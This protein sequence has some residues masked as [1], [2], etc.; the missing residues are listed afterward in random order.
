MSQGPSDFSAITGKST[1]ALRGERLM[2][3]ARHDS[4]AISPATFNV[5]RSL[6]VDIAWAEHHREVVQS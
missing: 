1:A 4:G 5:V 6:E 2:L 3:L